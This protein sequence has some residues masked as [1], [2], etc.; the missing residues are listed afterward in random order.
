MIA[1]ETMIRLYKNDQLIL[2]IGYNLFI[3]QLRN[4]FIVYMGLADKKN[5]SS[6]AVRCKDT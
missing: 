5:D 1:H 2:G 3:N 6:F 4:H